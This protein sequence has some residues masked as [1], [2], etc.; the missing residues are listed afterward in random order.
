MLIFIMAFLIRMSTYFQWDPIIGGGGDTW[1]QLKA[2]Q[3]M[4]QHGILG[5]FSYIDNTSWYPYGR[6]WGGTEYLGIPLLGVIAY[7]LGNLIGL[8]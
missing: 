5:Y 7:H 3:Y 1:S 4:N 8:H 6:N 2:A